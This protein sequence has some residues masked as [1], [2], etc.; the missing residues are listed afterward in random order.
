MDMKI[1]FKDFSTFSKH[2]L[3][4]FQ[5]ISLALELGISTPWCCPLRWQMPGETANHTHLLQRQ[6]ILVL[7]ALWTSRADHCTHILPTS[8]GTDAAPGLSLS[9]PEYEA[10][11][12]CDP[13]SEVPIQTLR[14]QGFLSLSGRATLSRRVIL[15]RSHILRIFYIDRRSPCFR[16][17][18]FCSS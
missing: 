18:F 17:L 1:L 12:C 15:D 10:V 13:H 5:L 16:A 4:K 3:K 7:F 6:S 14:V 9:G 11:P 8:E 2:S